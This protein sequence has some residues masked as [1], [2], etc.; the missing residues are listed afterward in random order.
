MRHKYLW[1]LITECDF[2]FEGEAFQ[3]EKLICFGEKKLDCSVD[4]PGYVHMRFMKGYL[5]GSL[6]PLF[7]CHSSETYMKNVWGGLTFYYSLIL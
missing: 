6:L 3:F 1:D 7:N 5:S 2:L 4:C